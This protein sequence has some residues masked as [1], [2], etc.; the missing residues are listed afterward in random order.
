MKNVIISD[1]S[2]CQ[3]AH[4]LDRD[5]RHG[6]WRLIDYET[7]EFAGTMIYSGPGMNCEPLSLSLNCEGYHAIYVGVHYPGEFGDAHVRLRLTDDPAYTLVRAETQSGKDLSGIPPELRWS[8]T[9]KAFSDYQVSEAFWK[10]ADLTGVAL[11][12]SRFNEGGRGGSYG[13]MYSNLVYLRLVPLSEAEI[14][15]Y[16]QELPRQ[17]TKRLVAMNDAG[18]FSELRTKEDIWAQFEPYRDSDVKIMLWAT[19]KGENCT[20]RSRIGRTLTDSANPF[21]RFAAHERWD[22]TLEKLEGARD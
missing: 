7:E 14:E 9:T 11:I 2:Q 21:D 8:H 10:V 18:I 20:Y 6:T 12:I 19:F 1:L 16:R 4:R 13:E 17:D 22:L 3:P 15:E 5:Y